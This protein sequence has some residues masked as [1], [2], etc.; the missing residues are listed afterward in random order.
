MTAAATA[1][2]GK[3]AKQTEAAHILSR[4]VCLTLW[5]SYL[6]NHRKVDTTDIDIEEDGKEI[7]KEAVT[8]TKKLVDSKLLRPAMREI[9]KTKHYLRSMAIAA[10]RVFGEGTYLIPHEHV[11]EVDAELV[12]RAAAVRVAAQQVAREWDAAIEAQRVR[13]GPVFKLSDYMPAADVMRAFGI[14]WTYVS[15][16][17]PQQLE[18]VSKAVMHAA[19]RRFARKMD[20]LEQEATL[21]MRESA[22]Q[23]VADMVR[24]LEPG[25]DGKR[26]ALRGNAL[27]KLADYLRTFP[28]RNLADDGEL[29]ALVRQLRA[30]TDGLQVE[31][32]KDSDRLRATLLETCRQ[33]TDRLDALVEATAGRAIQFGG[34]V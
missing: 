5:C 22:R 10:H 24:K 3:T 31:D 13:L 27:E 14:D 7:S 19:Q 21:V 28:A 26:K 20:S 2:F 17:A 16:E 30:A 12:R 25:K 29:D 8:L 23:V 11:E 18:H 33:A 15:F 4:A 32:L 34:R 6:G 1:R 9:G